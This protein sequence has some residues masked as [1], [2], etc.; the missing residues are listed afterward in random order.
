MDW[1]RVVKRYGF[2]VRPWRA[3]YGVRCGLCKR[4]ALRGYQSP[5]GANVCRLCAVTR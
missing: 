4:F 1:G 5:S 2:E 3:V